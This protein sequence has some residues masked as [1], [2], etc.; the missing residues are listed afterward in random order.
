[1][2]TAPLV[3]VSAQVASL[4]TV[5]A[6]ARS[7][8]ASHFALVGRARRATAPR[9]SSASSRATTR[10]RCSA[11]IVAGYA[12]AESGGTAPRVAWVGPQ[13]RKLAATFARGVHRALPGAVV[14]D[15]WSRSIPAR[16][17]EAALAAIARGAMVVMAGD[18]LCA[19][20]AVAGARQQNVPGLQLGDFQFPNVAAG[21]VV[22]DALAGVYH[23]GEDLSFGAGS[24]A[25]GVGALDP[26]ISFDTLVRARTAAQLLAG[27]AR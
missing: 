14:L 16:C 11:G 23:G 1:M 6:A 26:R 8:P 2:A 15:E 3:L 18:G 22:R 20:A 19:R 25:I 5:A 12:A 7:H 21:L 9:T 4:A 10:R 13:E 17:K 27:G 24:G